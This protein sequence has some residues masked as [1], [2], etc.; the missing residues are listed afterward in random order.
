MKAACNSGPLIALAKI[1]KIDLLIDLFEVI[2]VP[3]AVYDEVVTEGLAKGEPDAFLLELMLKKQNFNV[4]PISQT[5]L[6]PSLKELPLDHGE[7]HTIHLAIQEKADLILLDDLKARE[8][9]KTFGLKVKGSLGILVDAFRAN[10]MNAD[11]IKEAFDLLRKRQDIWI[12]EDLIHKV[13]DAL[14]RG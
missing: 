10:L 9:A 11:E 1:S 4:V 13:W 8:A 14:R 5:E 3:S 12:A 2:L 7:K 6:L